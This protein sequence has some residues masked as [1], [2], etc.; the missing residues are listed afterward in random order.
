LDE[1]L[2]LS[3]GPTVNSAVFELPPETVMVLCPFEGLIKML[4]P[5]ELLSAN[6][7]TVTEVLAGT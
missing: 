3:F 2:L 7:S 4:A 1:L 5:P 6:A